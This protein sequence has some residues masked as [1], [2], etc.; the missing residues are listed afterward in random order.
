MKF[1]AGYGYLVEIQVELKQLFG[2]YAYRN[3]LAAKEG[4]A[5]RYN[6]KILYDS[7]AEEDEVDSAYVYLA[8]YPLG[9]S[10]CDM[11]YKEGLGCRNLQYKINRQLQ[12]QKR[13]K[14]PDHYFA[15]CL[16]KKF[17]SWYN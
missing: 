11:F 17:F 8:V 4:V 12:K 13:C 5:L 1:S 6:G 3:L 7:L 14:N 2:W 16:D 9:Q 15:E 10:V